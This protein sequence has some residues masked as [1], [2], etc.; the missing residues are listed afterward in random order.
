M[1]TAVAEMRQV[2]SGDPPRKLAEAVHSEGAASESLSTEGIATAVPVGHSR[3]LE[4]WTTP[5]RSLLRKQ[6]GR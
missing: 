4:A 6:R 2:A 3:S 1:P 5:Q